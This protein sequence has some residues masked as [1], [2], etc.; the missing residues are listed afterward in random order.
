MELVQNLAQQYLWV[1]KPCIIQDD[2]EE[3]AKAINGYDYY[4][5][6]FM[7]PELPFQGI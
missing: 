7:R 1:D 6:L 3:K 4:G 5:H 2:Q